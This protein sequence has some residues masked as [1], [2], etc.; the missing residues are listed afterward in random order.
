MAKNH[1]L[2]LFVQRVLGIGRYFF[3]QRSEYIIKV[4]F[5]IAIHCGDSHQQKWQ[6]KI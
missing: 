1:T 4:F 3:R 6:R 2:Y 5:P